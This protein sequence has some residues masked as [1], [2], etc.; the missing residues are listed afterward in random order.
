[1]RVGVYA[2]AKDEAAFVERWARSAE[3]ADYRLILDTGSSDATVT[4]AR[5]LG[6][7][8]KVHSFSPWRFDEA[9]NLSLAMLPADA[10]LCIALDLDEVLQPG[11]RDALE[12]AAEEGWTRP[13]Y[14]YTWSW[15][16]DG[17]PGLTYYG[18]KIHSRKGYRWKHPV[19]EVLV[20][21]GIEER[22]GVV[23]LEIH[24]HPDST[25]SRGQ[26]LPL[27]EL[28]VREDPE[29]DRNA[30]Y[31][32]R[33]LYYYGRREEAVQEFLRHLGLPKATWAPERA[34][35]MRFLAELLPGAR[36]AWLL[37]ACGE[38]PN[39]REP[40]VDLAQHYYETGNWA[41]CFSAASRALGISHRPVEYLSEPHAWGA[42][43]W[44]LAAL[45]AYHLGL[46]A[47][48][49]GKEALSRAPEDERLRGNL[50]W[51]LRRRH[52][53]DVQREPGEQRP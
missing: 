25:K 42:K 51:Y 47:V 21:D 22:Q 18:D 50:D 28:A 33:E 30:F 17:S 20:P 39:R 3:E 2:I 37:R 34:R 32:A 15:N 40:W 5:D 29:D 1:M 35:S 53:M 11:W 24:H 14:L 52:V 26:Y 23:D 36:E 44:D 12:K 27:L 10:D 38:C 6:V 9:R 41:G 49:L 31:Y 19:H 43:P 13:R 45:A 16:D 48:G 8:V 4:L 46:D 7:D